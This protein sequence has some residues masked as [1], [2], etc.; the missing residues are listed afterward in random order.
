LVRKL[1][2]FISIARGGGMG[3]PLKFGEIR[4]CLHLEYFVE[5]SQL[6]YSLHHCAPREIRFTEF[7]QFISGKH[8]LSVI[9]YSV[10]TFI[11]ESGK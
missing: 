10:M 8:V 1:L 6:Q 11:V 2:P 3:E 5:V 9:Q 4:S 7:W